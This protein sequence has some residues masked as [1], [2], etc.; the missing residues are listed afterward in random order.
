MIKFGSDHIIVGFIKTLLSDYKLPTPQ[1]YNYEDNDYAINGQLYIKDDYVCQYNEKIKDFVQLFRF[2]ANSIPNNYYKKLK[3]TG[4][5]YDS[6]THEYLGEYLRFIRDY[7]GVNLMPLYNCYSNSFPDDLYTEIAFDS[8]K[9]DEDENKIYITYIEDSNDPNYKIVMLPVKVDQLYTV[10]IDSSLP[11]EIFCGLYNTKLFKGT[12]N[13]NLLKSTFQKLGS[14]VFNSPILYDKLSY[15]NL[16]TNVYKY[17]KRYENSLKLFI[18]LPANNN[19]SIVILEGNYLNYNDWYNPYFNDEITDKEPEINIF[20][21]KNNKSV[22]N[23]NPDFED[24]DIKPAVK[25]D[26][27]LK[28]SLQLLQ[29]NTNISYPFADRLVEYLVDNA[30]TPMDNISENIKRLQWL[31]LDRY[32]E[33]KQSSGIPSIGKNYGIWDDKYVAVLY[34]LA[35]EENLLDTKTDILGY[36]DKDIEAKIGNYVNLQEREGN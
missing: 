21:R 31:L 25:Y 9:T 15:N 35:I 26:N 36:V 30:I 1:V 4:I 13:E 29:M 20:K 2:E 34:K 12:D 27:L 16:K 28:S 8:G 11:Y 22:L 17:A 19:S 6:H 14:G 7:K 3:F 24:C 23:I 33:G 32:K 18:K 5:N 10:A